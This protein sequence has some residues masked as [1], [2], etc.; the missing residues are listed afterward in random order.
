MSGHKSWNEMSEKLRAD[1]ERRARIEQREQAIEAELTISQIR[2]VRGAT[3]ENVAE[4]RRQ[5]GS[6]RCLS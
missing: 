2:E 4:N 3:Q 1:L 6:S 5:T